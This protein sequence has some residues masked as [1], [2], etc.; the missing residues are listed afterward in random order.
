MRHLRFIQLIALIVIPAS[1]FATQIIIGKG[2]RSTP[3]T[4]LTFVIT[5]PSGTSPGTSPCFLG[6]IEVPDCDF[7][8]ESGTTWKNLFIQF[9]PFQPDKNLQ[10]S[11]GP[12]FDN[13]QFNFGPDN[14]VISVFFSNTPR[15][16][17]CDPNQ[18]NFCGIPSGS[19]G[20]FIFDVK[21]FIAPTNFDAQANV[22]ESATIILFMIGLLALAMWKYRRTAALL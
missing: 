22:P 14:Q 17:H 13:C 21:G 9:D 10:C 15:T 16:A 8:N 7:V 2:T 19:Q 1:S 12:W 18:D 3:I 20:D 5:S 6:N 4:T 11:G